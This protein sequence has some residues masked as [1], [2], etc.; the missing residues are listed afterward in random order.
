MVSYTEKNAVAKH[1]DRS[2]A[3][4]STDAFQNQVRI[5]HEANES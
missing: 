2:A 3:E 1:S 5:Y 4:N